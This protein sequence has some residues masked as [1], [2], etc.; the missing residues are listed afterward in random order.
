MSVSYYL[1]EDTPCCV[2]IDEHTHAEKAEAYY[3][4][5]GLMPI[6]VTPVMWHGTLISEREYKRYVSALSIAGRKKI[7]T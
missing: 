7:H 5:E 4:G 1:Y 3:A 6:A 2:T